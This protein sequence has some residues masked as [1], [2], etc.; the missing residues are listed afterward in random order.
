MGI[1]YT[2]QGIEISAPSGSIIVDP[3]GVNSLFNFQSNSFVFAG[4]QTV[5]NETADIGSTT[6]TIVVARESKFLFLTSVSSDLVYSTTNGKNQ[7]R[8]VLNGTNQSPIGEFGASHGQ[9]HNTSLLSSIAFNNLVTLG[10]GTHTVK[11]TL[12]NNNASGAIIT[13]ASLTYISL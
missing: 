3:Q 8:F 10:A 6:G 13:N 1:A 4:T 11:L 9:A 12:Q 5:T 2:S 7:A